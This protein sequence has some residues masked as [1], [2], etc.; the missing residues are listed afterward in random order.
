[1]MD[2]EKAIEIAANILARAVEMIFV[3]ADKKGF[4][5]E[6]LVKDAFEGVAASIS[7]I[8]FEKYL[9]FIHGFFIGS[10]EK[11]KIQME[12]LL[13][14]KTFSYVSFYVRKDTTLSD[15]IKDTVFL[16]VSNSPVTISE[17]LFM[18]VLSYAFH[19]LLF[20]STEIVDIIPHLEQ[21]NMSK[22]MKNKNK[23]NSSK[24]RSN[25]T[26]SIYDVKKWALASELTKKDSNNQPIYKLQFAHWEDDKSGEQIFVPTRIVKK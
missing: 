15:L 17:E 14:D 18:D 5:R 4:N 1:M 13:T 8:D 23:K 26:Y 9:P 24:H 2:L 7:Y 3:L 21:R 25:K 16:T 19:A 10:F 11:N 6:K 20:M 22:K 12:I